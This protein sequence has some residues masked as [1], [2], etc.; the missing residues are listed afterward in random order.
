MGA[1]RK[2]LAAVAMLASLS[3]LAQQNTP[4]QAPYV[5]PVVGGAVISA[6]N[7][8]PVST[9]G[10]APSPTKA[11]ISA[12]GSVGATS[13]TVVPAAAY[14][15]W[16]TIQNT[17]ANILYLS[18]T[19]PA[20]TSGIAVAAGAALTLPFGPTNALFGIGSATATTFAVVGY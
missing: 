15:G 13:A 10:S 18:F 9:S 20:T 11:G 19:N 3:A 5:A 1:M 12:T 4:A 16:V 14:T 17:S 2:I 6:S 7:P 8:L